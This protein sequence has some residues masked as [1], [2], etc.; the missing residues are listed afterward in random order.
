MANILGI[1]LSAVDDR[2]NLWRD[3]LQDV[4]SEDKVYGNAVGSIVKG[5]VRAFAWIQVDL[6][7]YGPRTLLE[8]LTG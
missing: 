5:F 2:K 8:S 3:Q 1:Q 6:L 4:F 7:L